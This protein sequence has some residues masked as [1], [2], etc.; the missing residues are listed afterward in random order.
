MGSARFTVI[1]PNLI[2]LEYSDGGHF[3]DEPTLFAANRWARFDGAK[4]VHDGTLVS[5]RTDAMKLTY[6]EDGRPFKLRS[7]NIYVRAGDRVVVWDPRIEDSKNLGGT[8]RTLDGCTGPKDLGMGLISRS[9]WAVVDDSKMPILVDGWVKSRPN[10]GETDWY[11]FGYGMDYK[12]A[13]KSLAA[14]SGG[15][16]LP[17]KNQLG[18]WYSRYWP[19]TAEEYRQ[20]VKEYGDHGFPLD[21]IVM[22]MDWHITQLPA[23]KR[24]ANGQIWTGYTWDRKLLPDAEALLK[25]FHQQGLHV[26]LNDHPADGVQAHEQCY[27]DFMRAMGKDPATTQPLAFDA[28]DRNYMETFWKFTHK[29]LEQEGVD[30]WWLDWQQFPF[31]RSVADLGTCRG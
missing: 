28:G 24:G 29:P 10:Q 25:W 17:R 7:L 12:A 11:L 2:R 1:T 9:G 6:E 4:I 15:V 8:L 31:T 23:V 20:I 21:N 14:I 26:T 18:I 22:D 3:T 5:I 13:L 30:F 27:A 19:Y 16:S